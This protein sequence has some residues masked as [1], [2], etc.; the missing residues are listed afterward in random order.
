MSTATTGARWRLRVGGIRLRRPRVT[1]F[2]SAT[3]VVLLAVLF[4][5]WLWVRSSSLVA[6]THVRVTGLSG[7]NVG[8]IRSALTN[9]ALTM[10]TLDISTA[11]LE[12]AVSGYPHIAGVTVS[13]GF[14]HAVTIHVDEQIPL[15]VVESD[16]RPVAVDAAGRL[17]ANVPT[18]GLT[19]LSFAPGPGGARVT[20]AGTLA[21]LT[22]LAAAPYQMLPHV[23]S[24]RSTLA[25]GVTLQLRDGPALYFGNTTELPAKWAAVDA[26]LANPQSAGAAYIDV[27]APDR[28]AAG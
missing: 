1:A 11:K 12:S 15:A 2:R 14:P 8:A 19:R 28:P 24:A 26:V 20:S 4:A 5:G 3:L 9:E 21:T 18:A 10:T 27:S 16:G 23:A 17:L 25:H 22:V 13:T 6:V 7:A